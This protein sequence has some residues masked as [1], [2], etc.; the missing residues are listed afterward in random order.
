MKRIALF[1]AAFGA[2]WSCHAAPPVAEAQIKNVSDG[3]TVSIST[4][5]WTAVPTTVALN[6]RSGI[7]IS[8]P[9]SNSNNIACILDTAAPTEAITIRPIEIQPGENPF[10]QARYDIFLYCVSLHTAAMSV[11]A[12]EVG[13]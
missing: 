8:N 6:S 9:S 11:H 3:T 10:I 5:A 4:S 13:Q 12:Q 1:L 7:K 2:A